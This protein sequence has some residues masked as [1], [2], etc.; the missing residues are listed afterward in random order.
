MTRV[1]QMERLMGLRRVKVEGL[2][3][4]VGAARSKMNLAQARI[5]ATL[6]DITAAQSRLSMDFDELFE[7]TKVD[8]PHSR[9]QSV[10]RTIVQCR[11]EVEI[12]R[13]AHAQAIDEADAARAQ[14]TLRSKAYTTAKA[15]LDGIDTLLAG[16]RAALQVVEDDN[17]DDAALEQY[18]ASDQGRSSWAP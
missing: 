1:L 18:A 13:R 10:T 7:K 4:E 6:D 16:E 5:D 2:L 11:H 15:Q 12:A 9:L 3:A 17:A 8:D 14:L